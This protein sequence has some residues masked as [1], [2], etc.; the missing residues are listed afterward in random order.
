M[1]VYVLLL[2]ALLGVTHGGNDCEGLEEELAQKEN[3][4]IATLVFVV[5][6]FLILLFLLIWFCVR[7]NRENKPA[8]KVNRQMNGTLRDVQGRT[9]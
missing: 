7:V 1:L 3:L 6:A 9:N 5:L 8:V 2:L 4:E